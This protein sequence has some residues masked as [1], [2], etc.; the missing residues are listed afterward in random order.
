MIRGCG[1]GPNH[2]TTTLHHYNELSRSGNSLPTAHSQVEPTPSNK[3]K[4]P[5]QT[6]PMAI[7]SFELGIPICKCLR[8]AT[9]SIFSSTALAKWTSSRRN[10]S[11]P[12]RAF[13]FKGS[14]MHY[15]RTILDRHKHLWCFGLRRRQIS[16][17]V[18]NTDPFLEN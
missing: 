12:M 5:L 14:Q 8:R 11:T 6:F 7:T 2:A 18:D 17:V 16:C 13:A 4:C 3:L 15:S 10:R 9:S 1:L